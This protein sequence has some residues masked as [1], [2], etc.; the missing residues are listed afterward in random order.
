MRPRKTVLLALALAVAAA[1]V[2]WFAWNRR[3]APVPVLSVTVLG[4]TNENV[5]QPAEGPQ[6]GWIEP[7]SDWIHV[8]VRLKNE[9]SATVVWHGWNIKPPYPYAADKG[10]QT[11]FALR[12]GWYITLPVLLPVGTLRW[13]CGLSAQ[14]GSVR[15]RAWLSTIGAGRFNHGRLGPVFDWAIR[16]LP[17]KPE[18]EVDL[19]SG[20][21]T[22]G[23]VS[24]GPPQSQLLQPADAAP[25]R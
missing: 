21:F 11:R 4:Y 20:W 24:N 1:A 9:G 23:A 15:Y 13:Q 8:E 16:F 5:T 10:P 25:S 12:P 17:D 18:P 14:V 22:V 7:K 3:P 6:G 2:V 19:Y